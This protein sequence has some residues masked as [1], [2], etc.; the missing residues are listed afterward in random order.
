M[1]LSE[2]LENIRNALTR[3]IP[4]DRIELLRAGLSIALAEAKL[5]ESAIHSAHEFFSGEWEPD[6][7]DRHKFTEELAE[8][9]GEDTDEQEV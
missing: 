5:Q 9:V 7:I 4:A 8:L 1:K 2:R 6:D 3:G